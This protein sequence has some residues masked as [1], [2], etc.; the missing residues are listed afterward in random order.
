MENYYLYYHKN[1]NTKELF[2]IGIGTNKRAW[3][4]TSGRN[5]HYKNY[6]KKHGE[7]IVDIIKGNITV[8][9]TFDIHFNFVS[10]DIYHFEQTFNL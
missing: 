3:D 5:P 10:W 6:I 8:K 4:F 2:Y 7:P 1:P 9:G